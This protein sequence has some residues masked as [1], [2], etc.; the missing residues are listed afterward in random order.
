[1]ATLVTG[2]SGFVGSLLVA[3]LAQGGNSEVRAVARDEGRVRSA[4]QRTTGARALAGVE[5]GETDALT[6]RGLDRALDDVD[7]AY[8]L[9]HSL[10]R[11]RGA[12]SFAERERRAAENFATAAQRAGVR[13]I[14][15]LGGLVPRWRGEG[16]KAARARARSSRHLASREEVERILLAA[17]RGS[18]ALRASIIIGARSRSFRLMVRLVERMPV[19]ALP[20]WRGFRT[21]PIDERDVIAMLAAARTADVGG[22]TLDIAGPDV[23]TYGDM[24][25]AIAEAMLVG[26]PAISLGVSLTPL[27]ARIAAAIVR[28]DPELVVPLMEGLQGDL[29]TADDRAAERLGVRL[30][31]FESAVEHALAD[32][33]QH[34]PLAAR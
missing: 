9:I 5:V 8:Y 17:V 22:R 21:Q 15:Y 20:S 2:A 31:S 13:R 32:W 27:T 24:L 29:L 14:V 7:V 34:E 30:H 10:E 19:L 25:R 1:M 12:T 4:L 6:G 33:E 3:R 16:Q 26:R 23:L 28:E 11:T 18:V